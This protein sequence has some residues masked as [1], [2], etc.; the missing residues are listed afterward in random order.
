M[1]YQEKK[2][3]E[4]ISRKLNEQL[5]GLASGDHLI[6]RLLS[7]VKGMT[8]PCCPCPSVPGACGKKEVRAPT[9]PGKKWDRFGK[10]KD[11]KAQEKKW[12]PFHGA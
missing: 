12:N 8:L 7:K 6:R 11:L 9:F 4:Q 1:G 2:I 10:D 5:E 3:K